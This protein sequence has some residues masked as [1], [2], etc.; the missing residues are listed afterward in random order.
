MQTRAFRSVALCWATILLEELWRFGIRSICLAPGSRSTPLVMAAASLSFEIF[1]HYDERSL[2]FYAL[3]LA[4]SSRTPVVII[5]TSGTA[6]ANVLPAVIEASQSGVPLVVIS[7]DRPFELHDCAA[8]QSIRQESIFEDFVVQQLSFPVADTHLPIRS[9]LRRISSAV[10]V[11]LQRQK[12]IHF[13]CPF[14]EPFLEDHTLD[15]SEY[16]QPL[17]HYLADTQPFCLQQVVGN[18]RDDEAILSSVLAEI[19]LTERG[20]LVC[21]QITDIQQAY[22]VLAL[23]ETYQWPLLVD[24][25]SQLFFKDHPLVFCD[26]DR[27]ILTIDQLQ[28]GVDFVVLWVGGGLLSKKLIELLALSS[29]CLIR[30]QAKQECLDVVSNTRVCLQGDI[31]GNLAAL[32][33]C[34]MSASTLLPLFQDK[35]ARCLA[36]RPFDCLGTKDRVDA[37]YVQRLLD[38]W[39][40]DYVCF[41]SNSLPVRLLLQLGQ[42]LGSEKMIYA[43][44]GASG[45]DGIVSTAIGVAKGLGKPLILLIGDLALLHDMGGLALV[46]QLEIPIKICCLNN[47][48]GAIFSA[49][50]IVKESDVFDPYFYTP[51]E[52]SFEGLA[53]QFDLPYR[54]VC[55]A[56][57]KAF[58]EVF[59][60][61]YD[62][63]VLIDCQSDGFFPF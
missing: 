8:N 11:M 6:V 52:G 30:V 51:R 40:K 3:G 27:W 22:E 47:G 49:L 38:V 37:A 25:L 28:D 57:D 63:S 18:S 36:Q 23:A 53:M 42:G 16:L 7:A 32:N 13:N 24:P 54:Q 61:Q 2:G 21:G 26:Y 45:I 39:P 4:L 17:T 62:H 12:P 10:S 35:Q 55:S 14:R 43:N 48:G 58:E 33:V 1:T 41:V 20:M 34:D 59:S 5:T 9:F 46:K 31:K 56:K 15:F 60:P 50:P 29:C 19:E 44:R